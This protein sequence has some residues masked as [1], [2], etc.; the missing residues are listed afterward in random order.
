LFGTLIDRTVQLPQILP[1]QSVDFSEP[2]KDVPPFELGTLRLDV[3]DGTA[4]PPVTSSAS[5]SV[6]MIP[7]Y[8]LLVLLLVV[9]ASAAGVRFWRR[10]TH[11]P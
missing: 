6:S 11:S 10:R 4:A 1:G 2:W 8:S 3:T 5:V 9:A 7:W